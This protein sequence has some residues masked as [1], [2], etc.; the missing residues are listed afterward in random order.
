LRAYFGED[1]NRNGV[2]DA[3]EDL[4]GDGK[5]TRYILPTPPTTPKVKLSRIIRKQQ[6]IGIEEQRISIDPISGKK[7]LKVINFIE[8]KPDLI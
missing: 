2:L 1:R 3:N 4:D 7:I 6:F 5:I 8:H